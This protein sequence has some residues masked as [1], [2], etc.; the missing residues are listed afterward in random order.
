MPLARALTKE[1][2]RR[3]SFLTFKDLKRLFEAEFA[4]QGAGGSTHAISVLEHPKTPP[5]GLGLGLGFRVSGLR[6][7]VEGLGFRV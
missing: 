1:H 5:A 4:L 7:R 6:L 3:P 2:D